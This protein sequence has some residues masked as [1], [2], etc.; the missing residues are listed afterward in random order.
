[1]NSFGTAP[2]E[3]RVTG[4]MRAAPLPEFSPEDFLGKILFE[5]CQ[6]IHDAKDGVQRRMQFCLRDEATHVSLAGIAGAIAPIGMC[7]VTGMVDWPEDQ[8]AK[9][10][11]RAVRKGEMH[12]MIF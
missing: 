12:E 3:Y 1:M 7:K 4:W 8:I 9:N 5:A 2:G 11:A 6:K 10:R